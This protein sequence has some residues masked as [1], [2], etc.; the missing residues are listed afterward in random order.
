MTIDNAVAA[1]LATELDQFLRELAKL[2]LV[3]EIEAID[4]AANSRKMD[5]YCAFTLSTVSHIIAGNDAVVFE[6]PVGEKWL[7][8]KERLKT[9]ARIIASQF[10]Q[11]GMPLPA[12][13][14]QP[15]NSPQTDERHSLT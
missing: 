8:R 4:Q 7:H 6:N 3:K 5:I 15:S 12:P 10:E 13:P 2:K 11:M 9:L 1:Q 14:E